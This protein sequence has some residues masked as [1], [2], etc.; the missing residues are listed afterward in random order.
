MLLQRER[1]FYAVSRFHDVDA[2]SRDP[3]TFVSAHGTVLE[4]MTPNPTTR[5]S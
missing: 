3:K 5:R 1:D 4:M 2:A